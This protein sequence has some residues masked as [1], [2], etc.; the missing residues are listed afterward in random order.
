MN[1]SCICIHVY[2]IHA[3]YPQRSVDGI[4]TP[5]NGITDVCEQS[6]VQGRK[7]RSF[8]REIALNCWTIAPGFLTLSYILLDLWKQIPV[9]VK[10]FQNHDFESHPMWCLS[11]CKATFS[12]KS[13]C[14]FSLKKNREFWLHAQL[15]FINPAWALQVWLFLSLN[16]LSLQ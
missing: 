16:I 9:L 14:Y 15:T 13:L 10:L 1:A 5:G 3:W 7:A 8:A 12:C 2:H 11:I 6:R 4:G